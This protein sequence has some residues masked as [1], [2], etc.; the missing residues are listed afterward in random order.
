MYRNKND[1]DLRDN[2][3]YFTVRQVRQLLIA[4]DYKCQRCGADL[5]SGS[6][7]THHVRRHAD[8]GQ[9]EVYNGMVLCISCHKEVT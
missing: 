5:K 6:F 9:T 2:R 1:A 8:G 4:A 7:E 3:R